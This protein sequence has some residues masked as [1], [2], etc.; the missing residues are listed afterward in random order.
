MTR[1]KAGI[2]EEKDHYGNEYDDD[3]Y[4]DENN[5]DAIPGCA[6]DGL[7][8]ACIHILFLHLLHYFIGNAQ[9]PRKIDVVQDN[10]YQSG[11]SVSMLLRSMLK[12]VSR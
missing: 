12:I 9:I 6:A 1:T 2:N 10:S 8:F 3:S 5:G 7:I 11:T 4:D